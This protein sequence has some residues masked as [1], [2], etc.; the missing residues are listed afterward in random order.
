[1]DGQ[2]MQD[3]GSTS[4]IFVCPVIIPASNLYILFILYIHVNAVPQFPKRGD[5]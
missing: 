5:G 3:G 1:M 2:D 4:S